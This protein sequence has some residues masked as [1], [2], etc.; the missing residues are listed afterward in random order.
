MKIIKKCFILTVAMTV[1]MSFQTFAMKN[2]YNDYPKPATPYTEEKHEDPTLE[3][4][5]IWVKDDLCLRS[6][7]RE[8]TKKDLLLQQWDLGFI[9]RWSDGDNSKIR[10]TYSGKWTQSENE[11]WSFEFDDHTIPVGITKID[12]VLYAFNGYGE[13]QDGYNYWGDLKTAAD[14]L[15]T[16]EEPEFLAWLATQYVPECTSHE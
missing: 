6:K 1:M 4:R 15:V 2:D 5:W 14:G 3:F 12:D 7:T 9:S 16:S 13:L 10:E 11:V 8:Q